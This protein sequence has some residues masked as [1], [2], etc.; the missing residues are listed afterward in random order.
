MRTLSF[1]STLFVTCIASAAFPMGCA[2]VESDNLSGAASAD[3]ASD[4]ADAKEVVALLG[5]DKGHCSD[6]HSVTA[7]KVRAWG[8]AMST[9]ETSC[10]T[11]QGLSADD[12]INCLRSTPS[13]P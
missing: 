7:A 1:F 3:T 11:A 5:G 2:A 10:F 6:C 8:T 13:T 4:L 9:I 12:R